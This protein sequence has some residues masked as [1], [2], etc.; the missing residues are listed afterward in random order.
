MKVCVLHNEYESRLPSGETEAVLREVGLLREEGVQNFYLRKSTDDFQSSRRHQQFVYLIKH[1]L[2]GF[3]NLSNRERT[4]IRNADL[5]HI[6]NTFPF[7]G[8][9][10]IKYAKRMNKK[11]I[12][13]IHN[14]RLTCL[15]GTHYRKSN[16]CFK[17]SQ[18]KT[19]IFGMIYGC[20]RNSRFQSFLFARY[21]RLYLKSFKDVDLF[22]VLNNHT[23]QSLI[24]L[25]IKYSKISLMPNPVEGPVKTS[26]TKELNLLF[27]GRLTREKGVL[28]L[29]EAFKSA[30]ISDLGWRLHIAG[31]GEL[32]RE[33]KSHGEEDSAI[34]VHGQV[35]QT[36]LGQLI[37]DSSVV[38]VPS[39]AY[40][41][42]PTMVTKAAAHGRA[43]M[44]SDVGPLSE[45]KELDWIRA[46]LPNAS[47]WAIGL[48]FIANSNFWNT[49]NEGARAW[50]EST[51]ST[52]VV[53]KLMLENFK[54]LK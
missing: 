17:C 38:C 50:W 48:R 27:A 24:N 22:F 26:Q 35:S 6:H 10:I 28:I 51:S 54:S 14:A 18:N 12:L 36:T 29:I 9:R 25:G 46:Y 7:L 37:E 11:V 1:V 41:G 43:V 49:P 19:F 4:E 45:I 8:F 20:Y 23:R 42:F 47:E 3:P 2:L 21:M 53:K 15:S 44:I 5:L 31:S 16:P 33:I 32:L 30:K 52:Q 40:E 34:I 39:I 13:T